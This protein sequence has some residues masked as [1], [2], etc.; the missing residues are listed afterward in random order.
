VEIFYLFFLSGIEQEKASAGGG[1]AGKRDS[2]AGEFPGRNPACRQ[3]GIQT[4]GFESAASET[5]EQ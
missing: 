1:Q 4:E 2:P 3:A 5:S